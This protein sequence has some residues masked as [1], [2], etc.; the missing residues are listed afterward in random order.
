MSWGRR[1]RWLGALGGLLYG[2]GRCGG[3]LPVKGILL[4]GRLQAERHDSRSVKGGGSKTWQPPHA[5]LGKA[6]LARG[7]DPRQR[8]ALPASRL[9]QSLSKHIHFPAPPTCSCSP[10]Y[11]CTPVFSF[12][13]HSAKWVAS[14]PF[15]NRG[16][17]RA[18]R[19]RI[20]S[21]SRVFLGPHSQHMEV[22]RLGVKSELQLSAYTTATAM[23][24]PSC[25]FD[26]HHSS[27]Q[28]RILD[29]L[30]EARDRTCNLMVPSR[31]R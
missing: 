25:V 11:V 19:G 9:K 23:P 28:H 21:R 8:V 27:R 2:W 6:G 26:L 30:S 20:G 15:H 10:R 18:E 22:S 16:N 7:W 4:A 12:H 13:N 3:R 29:P 5:G 1:S 14:H 31:I 17:P 24:D